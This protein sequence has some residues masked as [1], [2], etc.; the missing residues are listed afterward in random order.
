MKIQKMNLILFERIESVLLLT[1]NRPDSLNAL[2]CRV[3]EELFRHLH[4]ASSDSNVRAVVITGSGDKAFVAGADVKEMESM[5]PM[6]ARAHAYSFKRVMECIWRSE[7][8]VIAAI[9]GFCLGGGLELALACDLRTASENARFGLPEVNLGVMPGAGG[10]QRLPRL[11][12]MTLAKEMCMTG[13]MLD[14]V[15]ALHNGL[16]NHVYPPESLIENSMMLARKIAEKSPV[17][18]SMIKSAMN[19]GIETD[20][21]TALA[22]E[23]ECFSLCFGTEGQVRLMREFTQKKK[24]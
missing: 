3:N 16:I 2:N 17:S 6:Q 12:G 9:N 5:S 10:T 11:I 13:N 22:L 21:E 20:I 7:K 23:I 14:A 24:V 15:Q 4:E 8:P 1:I 19:R 18:L